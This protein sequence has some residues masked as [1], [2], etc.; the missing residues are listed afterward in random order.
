ME[1]TTVTIDCHTCDEQLE[2]EVVVD[3][4]G[5]YRE[6]PGE[7]AAWHA[8]TDVTCKCGMAYPAD[9]LSSRDDIDAQVQHSDKEEHYDRL[10]SRS[11]D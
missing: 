6:Y 7:K 2:F 5:A 8:A 3:A 9:E 10:E 1:T 4:H 11:A